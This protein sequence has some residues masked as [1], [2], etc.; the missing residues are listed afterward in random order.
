MF[1]HIFVV[2]F[3]YSL[4]HPYYVILKVVFDLQFDYYLKLY[5]SLLFSETQ[6]LIL[7]VETVYYFVYRSP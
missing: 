3:V 6:L 1:S 7:L 4:F 2:Q 5:N